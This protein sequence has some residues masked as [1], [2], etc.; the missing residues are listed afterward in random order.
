MAS[1]I[2]N[3][4]LKEFQKVYDLEPSETKRAML[5]GM[6]DTIKSLDD[7]KDIHN[8]IWANRELPLRM[9]T[10]DDFK[11]MPKV[12]SIWNGNANT[13][14]YDFDKDFG[15]NWYNEYEN[16]PTSKIQF[17]ADK[18]GKD[19]K[20][21]I[22]DMGEEATKR[23]RRDIARG[24]NP[25]TSTITNIVAP[26]SVEDIERGES[27]STASVIGDI[28]S[29]ALYATPWARGAQAVTKSVPR[30]YRIL[31][32]PVSQG[33][34]SN[35]TAPIATEVY[36]K[37]A[38]DADNPREEF[39]IPDVIAGIGTNAVGSALMRGAGGQI[40]GVFPK[41]GKK[42]NEIGT[43]KSTKE[44]A[45]EMAKKY[46]SFRIADAD[47]PLVSQSVRDLANEMK[48][49]SSTN[50]ELYALVAGKNA[51]IWE[52]AEQPGKN[53]EEKVIS[54]LAKKNNTGKYN[55]VTGDG[56]VISTESVDDM[57]DMMHKVG[58]VSAP[59]MRMAQFN[60]KYTPS[61]VSTELMRNYDKLKIGQTEMGNG[62]IKPQSQLI[63]EEAFKNYLTNQL[64]NV[65]HEQGKALTR[66]PLA[67]PYI[68]SYLDKKAEEEAEQK[69]LDD[70]MR[71]WHIRLGGR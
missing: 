49:L 29:N 9:F 35:A 56:N 39:S 19:A 20:Q 57:I 27:P 48:T 31:S 66:I 59:D 1:K 24:G 36:D 28:A 11:V 37:V 30:L 3:E 46:T 5:S 70:I 18:Y 23:R 44:A 53:V 7:D 64:G 13:E 69:E 16:I 45:D 47:N 2:K 22:N 65:S 14:H 21:L 12:A 58:G 68:Q 52:I 54:W 71:R 38:Y 6:Y 43:G 34:L 15:P 60:P 10:N 67:G 61:P 41:A 8:F 55:V 25:V 4:I 42:L 40:Q 32:N 50:P 17:I 33:V 26:R 51:P 63:S 62:I